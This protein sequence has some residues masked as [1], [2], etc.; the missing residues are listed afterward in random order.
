M[1][2]IGWKDMGIKE[3][4]ELVLAS[5]L[6]ISSIVLIFIAFFITLTV[7]TGVIAAATEMCATALGLLGIGIY[8]RNALVEL[9]TK[10]TQKV[11]EMENNVNR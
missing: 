9:D 5:L 3:Q 8:A 1:Q 10:V 2:K 4:T 7:G 11:Q 6:V